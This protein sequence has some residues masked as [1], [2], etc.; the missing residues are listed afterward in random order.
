MQVLVVEDDARMAALLRQALAEEGHMVSTAG[1]GH[2]ALAIAGGAS[3]DAIVLDIMLPGVDG[4]TIARRLRGSGSRT[5]ILMLTA[6]DRVRDVVAGLDAGA[7]DY[8]TKPFALDELLA[9][10]RALGRRGP[11][12]RPVVLCVA[13]LEVDTGARLASRAGRAI[14]LTRKQYLLLELLMHNAGHVVTR[15][16]ILCAIWGHDT[17]VEVNTVEAFVSLLRSRIDHGFD[18]KLI[19]TVRGVGYVIREG[20][21]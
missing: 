20:V 12:T 3:F 2:Q 8:L 19:H 9:R 11:V 10:V 14:P 21:D 16:A 1:D 7:D 17:D 6:R 15:D 18:R 13:D 5:P 4:L